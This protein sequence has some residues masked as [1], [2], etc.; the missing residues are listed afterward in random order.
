MLLR[1]GVS[2]DAR[3]KVDRTPLHMAA[4]DGHTHIVELLIR[5]SEMLCIS[6]QNINYIVM[7]HMRHFSLCEEVI[8][9]LMPIKYFYW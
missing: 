8:G 4:A 9:R 1:A 5:V 6:L 2:R 7:S 3:T